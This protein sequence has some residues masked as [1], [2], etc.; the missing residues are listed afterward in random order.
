VETPDEIARF[1][2]LTD[3]D[4]IGLVFD[5]GHYVFGAQDFDAVRGLERFGDRVWYVHLK[6]CHPDLARQSRAERWDYFAS[7]RQGIFC[8]L[9]DGGV[10]F[11]SMLRWLAAHKYD[12]FMLV[13]QDV[14]PGMG[15]PKESARRNREYLRSIERHFA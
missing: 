9:G 13:E 10:D 8:E 14:L 4:T 2:E 6:D 11:P 1:L 7:L 5:S 3:P 12:R 15:F